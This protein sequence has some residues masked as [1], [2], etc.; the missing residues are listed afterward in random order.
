MPEVD[1]ATKILVHGDSL[2]NV[3]AHGEAGMFGLTNQ[4]VVVSDKKTLWGKPSLYFNGNSTLSVMILGSGDLTLEFWVNLDKYSQYTTPAHWSTSLTDD[5]T[6]GTY[7]HLTNGGSVFAA[8]SSETFEAVALNQWH[9]MAMVKKGLDIYSFL[10]GM[11]TSHT[12]LVSDMTLGYLIIGALRRKGEESS[13]MVGHISEI[14]VSTCARWTKPFTPQTVAYTQYMPA[15]I[16]IETKANQA[17]LRV[18]PTNAGG[19]FQSELYSQT[20]SV[21]ISEHNKIQT[22]ASLAEGTVINIKI[23]ENERADFYVAKH[24][25]EEK[26]NGKGKTLLVSKYAVGN[27][28]WSSVNVNTYAGSLLDTRLNKTWFEKLPISVKRKILFTEIRYTP[29]NGD[30]KVKT[31]CRKVFALSGAE[32]GFHVGN[33]NDEGNDL[34]IAALLKP[35]RYSNQ[36]AVNQHLR[37]PTTNNQAAV[38]RLNSDGSLYYPSAN[39][40]AADRVAFSVS[41]DTLVTTDAT[42]TYKLYT[43]GEVI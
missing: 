27:F 21:Q 37:S 5:N 41:A 11:M 16:P 29:G 32:M 3:S 4:N 22:I 18:Y 26:I 25:Y 10:D 35:A 23:S 39:Q 20:A 12:T 15:Q 7:W 30:Y 42:N 34:P 14:R 6:R 13:R 9:H 36:T 17:H 43:N 31:L 33:M 40:N 8:G 1:T 28:P 19:I 2:K 24:D 38:W